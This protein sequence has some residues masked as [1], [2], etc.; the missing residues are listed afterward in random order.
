[1]KIRRIMLVIPNQRWYRR[2]SYWHLHP[3]ALALLAAMLP[4]REVRIVDA[5]LDDLSREQFEHIVREWQPDLVGASVLANEFGVTGHI[6]CQCV[7][8]SRNEAITV[9]GGV[10]PTTRP[11]AAIRDESVD[12]AVIGEG[13]HL[14]PKLIAYL[15][16]GPLPDKGLAYRDRGVITIQE[17]EPFIQPLDALP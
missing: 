6:A 8:Q 16:G 7:K 5:N 12:Y 9:L 15:E 11:E 2:E 4:D 17:R 13:E 14:L 3:Y 1:M 10:Y